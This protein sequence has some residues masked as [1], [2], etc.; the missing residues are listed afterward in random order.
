MSKRFD[1]IEK[2][3]NKHGIRY[4]YSEFEYI[5]SKT[6]SIIICSIHGRFKQ[7]PKN[8]LNGQG[9]K[10][11]Y[12]DKKSITF[13]EFIKRGNKIHNCKYDYSEFEY[14]NFRTKSIII[15]PIHGR[16]EQLPNNHVN[17][18][19]GCDKCVRE[20]VRVDFKHFLTKSIECH[21][22][23]YTYPYNVNF[24][25]NSKTTIICP[26]HG[27]FEQLPNNH[28]NLGHGCSSC[29]ES[30]GENIID[31]YLS[32]HMI[33]YMREYKFKDCVYKR[34]LLFDFYLPK[35]NLCIEYQ[36]IQHF[37]PIEYM[38]GVDRYNLQV[39]KD[40]IKRDY[41]KYNGIKLLEISY[42][43]EINEVLDDIIISMGKSQF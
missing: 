6:K 4:D 14:K 17:M 43:M 27:R 13:E 22:D 29:K 8:H 32:T 23:K 41:C 28:Y 16:F 35:Y 15:C 42:K 10:K 19:Q 12:I 33:D 36:G 20:N 21:G 18:E 11:C 5:D 30:K 40:D 7:L 25:F 26:I 1:L 37:E 31:G 2:Y 39:I 34:E 9:C 3:Q 38:G 24:R